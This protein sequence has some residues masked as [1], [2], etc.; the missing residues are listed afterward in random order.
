M[1]IHYLP[2]DSQEL[3]LK[4]ALNLGQDA[5][6]SWE[7]WKRR[8][9]ID[10]IEDA[11]YRLFP[12]AYHNLQK[13]GSKDPLLE[14]LKGVYRLTWYRN[15]LLFHRTN[16]VLSAFQSHSIPMLVLKG[17]PLVLFYYKDHGLRPMNDFDVLVPKSQISLACETLFELGW[18][19][20]DETLERYLSLYHCIPFVNKEGFEIDLHQSMLQLS[21]QNTADEDFWQESIPATIDKV[22]I[23]ILQPTDTLF[24]VCTHGA[25][26]EKLNLIR[27]V[28]DA[29]TILRSPDV[30]IDWKRLLQT[31]RKQESVLAMRDTLVYLSQTFHAPIPAD[32]LEEFQ[33]QPAR[34]MERIVYYTGTSEK[35][36]HLGFLFKCWYI[37]SR[38]F[39]SMPWYKKMCHFPVYMQKILKIRYLWQVPFVIGWKALRRIYL[40]LVR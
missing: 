23:R 28:A 16:A 11:S 22:N 18:K 29:M 2:T 19:V 3:L 40:S 26:W 33:R 1:K 20:K 38:Q 17:V 14:K 34:T 7:E 5:I 39:Q 6:E 4:A 15:Q 8:E 21:P 31:S 9:D 13:Q 30:P 35:R 10:R 25:T 12:L 37:H 27:W 32:V 24:H 36:M